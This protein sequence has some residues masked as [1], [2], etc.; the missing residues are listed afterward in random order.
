M[1]AYSL[2]HACRCLNCLHYLALLAELGILSVTLLKIVS[3]ARGIDQGHNLAKD[4]TLATLSL[5]TTIVSFATSVTCS[6]PL[7]K[8]T[9]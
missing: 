6:G 4:I 1:L 3:D 7:N 2:V 9:F 5:V 8:Q